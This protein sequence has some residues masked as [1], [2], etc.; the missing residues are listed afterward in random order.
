[1]GFLKGR[2]CGLRTQKYRSG[3]KIRIGGFLP[4]VSPEFP[5]SG[6][7]R[8][9]DSLELFVRGIDDLPEEILETFVLGVEI[10]FLSQL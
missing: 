7:G 5:S 8:R 6:L 1:M 2:T 3:T 10:K 9:K 4:L